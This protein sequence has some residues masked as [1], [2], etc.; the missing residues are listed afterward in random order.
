MLGVEAHATPHHG[1]L[2]DGVDLELGDDA[3]VV[4]AAAKGPVEIRVGC[5]A[6]VDDTATGCDNFIGDDIVAG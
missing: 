6:D 1:R 4:T 5:L 3:K 2:G